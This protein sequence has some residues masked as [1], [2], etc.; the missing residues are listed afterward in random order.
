MVS[1]VASGYVGAHNIV[2]FANVPSHLNSNAANF[3]FPTSY[4]VNFL[5]VI[6]SP[7]VICYSDFTKALTKMIIQFNELTLID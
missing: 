5:L 7:K 2:T 4:E 1:N 3:P 6:G